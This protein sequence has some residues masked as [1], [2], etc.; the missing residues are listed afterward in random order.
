MPACR[1]LIVENYPVLGDLLATRL[2]QEDDFTVVGVAVSADRALE[3]LVSE[4]PEML[5]LDL[6]LPSPKEGLRV[7]REARRIDPELKILAYSASST[8]ATVHRSMMEGVNGFVVKT[9]SWDELIEA[10][11]RVRRGHKY[12]DAEASERLVEAVKSNARRLLLDEREILL[13]RYLGEGRVVKSI[14]VALAVSAPMVYKITQTVRAKLNAQTNEEMLARA[15][16][17]GY[18]EVVARPPADAPRRE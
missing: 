3:L 11:R 16:A 4:E 18:L 13:L 1:T 10:L 2:A 15:C 8:V 14:A 7:L 6:G 5:M 17:L 9:A 12:L